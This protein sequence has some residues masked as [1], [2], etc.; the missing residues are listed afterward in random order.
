MKKEDIKFLS[1]KGH[2]CNYCDFS[3]DS[4]CLSVTHIKEYAR[5][6]RAIHAMSMQIF[7]CSI[8]RR[9]KEDK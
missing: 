8:F 1:G 3:K 9:K 7:D 5:K 4:V 2:I 6:R